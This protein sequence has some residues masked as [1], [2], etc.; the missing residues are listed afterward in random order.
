MREPWIKLARSAL[1]ALRVEGVGWGYRAG[2]APMVEPT[3]LA[4]LALLAT[5]EDRFGPTDLAVA[6]DA[7]DWLASLQRPE[8]SLG[9]SASQPAPGWPT[10]HALVL[11]SALGGY[12]E[13]RR[14][15][16]AWLLS[17]A[18]DTI[19]DPSGVLGHDGT[20]V[21]WPWVAG[22]HSWLE[23]TAWAVL[24]LHRQGLARHARV[25]EGLRL[26][27]NRAIAT[28]G[29]NYGNRAV[30]GRRLRA[31]PD[32]TGLALL[33]LASQ[34]SASPAP[35]IERAA[36]TLLE[37][38]PALR[39]AP[40]LG[41]GLLGL[42]AWG[43]RPRAADAWLVATWERVLHRPDAAPRLALLLLAASESS[44]SLFG[45]KP[46]RGRHGSVG[47]RGAAQIPDYDRA[48]S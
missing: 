7:G 12:A 1:G 47:R 27:H 15:A 20:I 44:L 9:L 10:A 46:E 19:E 40:A 18:G 34:P 21:G 26:I 3:V 22:T 41:W 39:T 30:F 25:T 43:Q 48:G 5:T 35:L 2:S 36:R 32:T 16:M 31:Q 37:T 23:P 28:G 6:W 42:S 11:W 14:R 13:P 45:L 8:G 33:A 38:L 17:Q 24:A 29:W 4:A